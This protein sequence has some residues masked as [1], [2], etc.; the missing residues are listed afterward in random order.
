M[1]K[2]KGKKVSARRLFE[3]K[4]NAE[5]RRICESTRNVFSYQKLPTIGGN[6]NSKVNFINSFE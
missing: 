3:L 2:W 4:R 5:F 6:K 1:P